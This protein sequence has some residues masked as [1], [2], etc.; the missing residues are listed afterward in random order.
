MKKNANSS[1]T[2]VETPP[3][4]EKILEYDDR[5]PLFLGIWKRSIPGKDKD[6]TMDSYDE[7]H[8]KRK[9]TI[10]DKYP[11]IKNLSGTET[12]TIPI[13][14][15]ATGIQLALAWYFGQKE[16]PI[17]LFLA[18]SYVIG[19]SITSLYGVIIHE[20]THGLCSTS[21]LVNRIVGFIAN[22]CIPFPI[23]SSFRRYHLDHHAFQGVQGK[24]PDLPLKWEIHFV[25]GN[26]FMK[27]LFMFFYPAMYVIRGIALQRVNSTFLNFI[28][29]K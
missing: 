27:I 8:V 24:D 28:M 26:I 14:L 5:F 15:V 4:T 11:Q 7:P 25:K 18:V 21:P 13:T 22:I 19:G 6:I 17:W 9:L 12:K 23:F 16:T 2:E 3:K 20:A 1:A 10:L 29:M